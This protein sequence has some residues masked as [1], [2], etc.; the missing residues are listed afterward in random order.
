MK[1]KIEELKKDYSTGV[2]LNKEL[3][4]TLKDLGLTPQKIIDEWLVE[5]TF[6]DINPE[7]KEVI[8]KMK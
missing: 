6:M 5:K 7:T 2:R 1:L 3:F 4:E 8:F